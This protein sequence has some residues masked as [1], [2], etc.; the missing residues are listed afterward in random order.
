MSD[1]SRMPTFVPVNL[2]AS[3]DRLVATKIP[4]ILGLA[5]Q[6]ATTSFESG[7]AWDVYENPITEHRDEYDERR[8]AVYDRASRQLL[9]L[10]EDAE[11]ALDGKADNV[12][13]QERLQLYRQMAI[14]AG[15]PEQLPKQSVTA[16]LETISTQELYE[17]L[18]HRDD[19]FAVTLWTKD[20]LPLA[21]DDVDSETMDELR[22]HYADALCDICTERG[23]EFLANVIGDDVGWEPPTQD[24]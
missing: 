12:W 17:E 10:T 15:F 8:Y 5:N 13:Y 6:W 11:N 3:S 22:D 1:T 14:I 4:G 16:I 21:L 2:A 18:M 7:H 24:D 9:C 23:N 19:V 20:D